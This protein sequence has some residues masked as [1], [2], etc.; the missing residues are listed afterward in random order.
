MQIFYQASDTAG[1]ESPKPKVETPKD[2]VDP[3]SLTPD[4]LDNQIN[5]FEVG[6]ETEEETPDEETEETEVKPDTPAKIEP[7]AKPETEP[8]KTEPVKVD[9]PLIDDKFISKYSEK[10]QKILMKYK[11]K[12]I[13][14]VVKALANANELIGK[15]SEEVKR[16]L[17]PENTITPNSPQIF[18]L[19]QKQEEVEKLKQD[20]VLKQVSGQKSQLGLS[21]EFPLP[22]TLDM[23]SPEYKQ[24][25]KDVNYDFPADLKIFEQ[26]VQK[27]QD[28]LN[29]A[30]AQVTYLREN[31]KTENDKIIDTEIGKINE[32]FGE[33]GVDL[34]SLGIE[35]DDETIEK[36]IF[37]GKNGEKILDPEMF[38]YVNGEIPIL[39]RGALAWKF[40]N[41]E[42]TNILAKV[43]ETAIIQG[44][45]EATVEN[46]QLPINK[47]LGNSNVAG[48]VKIE[49]A[50]TKDPYLMN[51]DQLDVEIDR[52]MKME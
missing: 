14:E 5:Q 31:F 22:T 29:K 48:E 44:R 6:P 27:E 21:E 28:N 38:E 32:Y 46:K 8:E 42:G 9:E 43:K 2:E 30:Y 10:E 13:S 40:N 26:S 7:E 45:K 4:E 20:L 3:Y 35:F 52:L 47:G 16:E 37:V 50:G 19:N 1:G 33:A 49:T 11:D 23:K 41:T 34:K 18:P 17:F 36:L 51:K 39:K 12:P 25:L 15:K 24:W